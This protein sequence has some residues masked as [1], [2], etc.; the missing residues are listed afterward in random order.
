MR[1]SKESL[2][3][4]AKRRTLLNTVPLLISPLRIKFA[5]IL[6]ATVHTDLHWVGLSADGVLRPES[7]AGAPVKVELR[8]GVAALQSAAAYL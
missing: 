2:A 8:E 5:C 4:F 1:H 6:Q 7:V 3:P